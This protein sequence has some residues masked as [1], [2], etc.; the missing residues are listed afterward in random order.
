M[1]DW[2]NNQA[3]AVVVAKTKNHSKIGILSFGAY[4]PRLR[5]SRQGIADAVGWA[6][7]SV[8][9]LATGERAVANWDEDVITM[10]AEAGR[11][12]LRDVGATVKAVQL[13]STTLPFLD[14]SNS[15]V[16]ADALRCGKT[17][18]TEDLS[19]SRR[20]ATSAL[21]RLAQM[22]YANGATL[23]LASE[24]RD[25]QPGSLQEMR[26]GHGAAGILVGAGEPIALFKGVGSIHEDLVDQYR[27]A[28]GQ[29]DYPLE[30]RWVRD[31]G[32][33]KIVPGAIEAAL[34]DAGT[35]IGEIHRIAF[36]ASTSLAR[37][38]AQKLGVGTDLF[39]DPLLHNCGDCGTAHPLLML[40]SALETAVPGEQI[41]L[42]GFG[43]GADAIV[44]ETTP[45]LAELQ[46]DR[47]PGHRL[48]HKRQTDNYTFFVSLRNQISIDF[49]IRAERDNRTA[50]SALYRKRDAISGMLG[51]RCSDCNT[52]QFPSTPICVKC[53]A[54][55]SQTPESLSGLIG[56]VKS[57][58]ED[59]MAYTRSPPYI[60]GNVEFKDGANVMLEFTDFEPGQVEIGTRVRMVFR[61]KDYDNK[62]NFHRYFWKPAPLLA[63]AEE[64]SNG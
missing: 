41:L 39:V 4:I 18:N 43:Q 59:W 35:S 48:A 14:R 10:A 36:P 60:Y 46:S 52:L 64:I 22:N 42:L 25:T 2:Q 19:G 23:L 8:K 1:S 13:A 24:C 58:T 34:A 3:Q 15:G 38:L 30:E 47:G 12:C 9:G 21:I 63:S 7:P 31:E 33:F 40:A 26:Y 5:M 37:G 20:A 6:V 62:R 55:E 61:V 27:S 32:Y 56:K 49:G 53:G 54:H 45:K 44:L 51:G 11:E 50:L 28:D 57:Y 17:I 29:Y 16:V